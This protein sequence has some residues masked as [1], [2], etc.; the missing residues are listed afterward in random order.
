MLLPGRKVPARVRIKVDHRLPD[1]VIRRNK[2]DMKT[3]YKPVT[4]F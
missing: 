2:N 1:L 3:G 4:Q